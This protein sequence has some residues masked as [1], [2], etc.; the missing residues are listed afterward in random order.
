M[1]LEEDNIYQ[2]S[3]VSVFFQNLNE[4]MYKTKND[5]VKHVLYWCV[6]YEKDV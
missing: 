1:L 5:K 4:R 6:M 2:D 3:L